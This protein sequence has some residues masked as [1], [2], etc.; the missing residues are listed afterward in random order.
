VTFQTAEQMMDAEKG[1]VALIP[2]DQRDKDE[3][4]TVIY[5]Y[6]PTK[7]DMLVHTV[8][9][10]ARSWMPIHCTIG[11]WTDL[12]ERGQYQVATIISPQVHTLFAL[13]SSFHQSKWDLSRPHI[14]SVNGQR[15]D[16]GSYV[17][18]DRIGVWHDDAGERI[19]FRLGTGERTP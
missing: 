11:A 8:R 6:Q 19:N 3:H 17:C 1:I 7:N 9:F 12:G 10:V 2:R 18:F 13:L 16:V 4:M 14:T 5:G 15:R